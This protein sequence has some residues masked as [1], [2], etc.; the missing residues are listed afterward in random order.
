MKTHIVKNTLVTAID[1]K[2]RLLSHTSKRGN[3]TT[4]DWIIKPSSLP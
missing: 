2:P 3:S 1:K 4:I